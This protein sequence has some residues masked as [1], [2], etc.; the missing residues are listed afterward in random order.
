MTG[1]FGGIAVPTG[2]MLS[3]AGSTVPEGFLEAEGSAVSRTTYADLF[4]VIGTT[5]G[6]GD[7]STTFNV[8]D[9]TKTTVINQRA[10]APSF[11]T[12]VTVP[13]DV[14]YRRVYG[15]VALQA[16]ASVASRLVVNRQEPSGGPTTTIERVGLPAGLTG[17]HYIPFSFTVKGGLNYIFAED[18]TGGFRSLTDYSYDD[19]YHVPSDYNS[20]TIIKT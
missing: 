17:T 1:L 2:T 15:T 6:S 19:V 11:G 20:T 10:T 16:S 14:L 7:G 9:H 5:Y 4:G 8:P 3:F 13:T 12:T 18:A